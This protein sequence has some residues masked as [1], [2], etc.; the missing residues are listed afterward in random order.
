MPMMHCC[1]SDGGSND[2]NMR[3]LEERR[4]DEG[5]VGAMVL[6]HRVE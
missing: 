2:R 3:S 4:R 6:V 1:C 5:R